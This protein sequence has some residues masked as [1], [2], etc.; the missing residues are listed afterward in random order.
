VIRL[1]LR[2]PRK[3]ERQKYALPSCVNTQ[4]SQVTVTKR[5]GSET[6]KSVAK[7]KKKNYT[8]LPGGLLPSQQEAEYSLSG[9]IPTNKQTNKQRGCR[10]WVAAST[11]AQIQAVPAQSF[12]DF[13]VEDD[14]VDIENEMLDKSIAHGG[15][16]LEG[17]DAVS[18]L[19]SLA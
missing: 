3:K 11:L 7:K 14:D 2:N 6:N 4:L 12:V 19:L 15:A 8:R 5:N 18:A 16:G 17:E 1:G 10:G 13:E 9:F